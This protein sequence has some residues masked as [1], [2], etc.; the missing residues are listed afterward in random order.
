MGGILL[1]YMKSVSAMMGGGG[2]RW[3]DA[4][5]YKYVFIGNRVRSA[6]G[7]VGGGQENL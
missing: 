2:M 5:K 3:A 1:I 7:K 6:R 4:N